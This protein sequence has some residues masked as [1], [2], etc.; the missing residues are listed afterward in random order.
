M[1]AEGATHA[2]GKI[3]CLA[4]GDFQHTLPAQPGDLYGLGAYLPSAPSCSSLSTPMH[5]PPARHCVPLA[6]ATPSW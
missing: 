2:A 6:K 1:K 4:A 3:L 5:A